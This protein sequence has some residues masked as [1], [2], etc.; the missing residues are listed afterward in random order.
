MDSHA[1]YHKGVYFHTAKGVRSLLVNM[2]AWQQRRHRHHHVM[3]TAFWKAVHAAAHRRLGH[4]KRLTFSTAH[5]TK[6]MKMAVNAFRGKYVRKA[7]RAWRTLV[8]R[9][10]RY[11]IEGT[12]RNTTTSTSTSS[13]SN[14]ARGSRYKGL[15]DTAGGTALSF[16]ASGR[17]VGSA[18]N[19][20]VAKRTYGSRMLDG[21]AMVRI[22][23]YVIP[24]FS[25][26]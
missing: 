13:F 4:W 11:R 6:A 20:T 3:R 9:T 12:G 24:F 14:S 7:M 19:R 1:S 10:Q 18:F 15:G 16:S 23:F 17:R 8:E 2:L 22:L 5:A 25:W 26:L 21:R